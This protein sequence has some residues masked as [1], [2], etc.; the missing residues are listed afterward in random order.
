MKNYTIILLLFIASIGASCSFQNKVAQKK[1]VLD[2]EAFV[3]SISEPNVQLLDIRTPMEYENDGHFQNAENID[4]ESDNFY[5]KVEKN[6]DKAKPLYL[7]C[8]GGIK[9]QKASNELLDK[10][11]EKVYVLKGGYDD[12][13]PEMQAEKKAEM[14]KKNK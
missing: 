12:W 1:E 4:Y 13:T 7:H 14:K 5:S 9:S 6:F 10:G 8:K 11:F 3:D 2:R